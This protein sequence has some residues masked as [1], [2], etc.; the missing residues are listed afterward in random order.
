MV[1]GET[2]NLL[3]A[4]E[5]LHVI[6]VQMGSDFAD[7]NIEGRRVEAQAGAWVPGFARRTMQAGLT[8]AEH[9]AGIPGALGGLVC[10]NG[11]S[12]R[13]GIGSSIVQVLSVDR[14]GHCV[15]RTRNEC[16][17]G[18]R[19]SVFQENGE[20]IAR[21]TFEFDQAQDRA[22]VRREMLRILSTRRKKFPRKQPNCGSVF[23]SDPAMYEDY[24]PPGEIIESL[25][26]KGVRV[27]GAQVSNDHAN[28]IINTGSATSKDVLTLISRIRANVFSET[29]YEM[30]PEV[31]FVDSSG[32]IT[33]A[34]AEG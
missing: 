10:M 31:L 33:P 7:V 15:T 21:A 11:G 17:F 18:Y 6:C 24:G 9:I 14:A 20:V 28:F 25:G 23:K 13:K 8:G 5:G 22:G 19:K 12:Q 1:I 16:E 27:G 4:D 3:F 34:T 29:G 32:R 2:S 30:V 26:W